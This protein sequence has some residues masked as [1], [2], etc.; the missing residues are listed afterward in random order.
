MGKKSVVVATLDNISV[1]DATVTETV[2]ALIASG[3]GS[4]I[5][6]LLPIQQDRPDTCNE[7]EL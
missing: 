1:I 6:N 3:R 4:I 5:N 7:Q 2:S